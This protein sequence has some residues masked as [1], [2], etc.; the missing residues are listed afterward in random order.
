MAA[1]TTL[2]LLLVATT[3]HPATLTSA[4]P[5]RWSFEFLGQSADF[6]NLFQVDGSTVFNSKQSEKGAI[7]SRVASSLDVRFST[8][9]GLAADKRGYQLD[10]G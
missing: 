3:A 1:K 8:P 7:W 5:V 6:T 2:A 9:L 4:T 10:R